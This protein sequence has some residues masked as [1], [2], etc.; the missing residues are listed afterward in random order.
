MSITVSLFGQIEDP[1]EWEF[2]KSH[3]GGNKWELVFTAYIET[4]WSVYSQHLDE[5]GPVPTSINFNSTFGFELLGESGESGSQETGYDKIFEMDV[6]KYHDKMVLTQEIQI[7]PDTREITG[8]VEYMTCDDTRCLPPTPVDFIFHF[9]SSSNSGSEDGNGL[10]AEPKKKDNGTDFGSIDLSEFNSPSPQDNP[11][12]GHIKNPIIWQ[13]RVDNYDQESYTA[14][15]VFSGTIE[16]GWHAYSSKMGSEDGPIPLDILFGEN[17]EGYTFSPLEEDSEE[18]VSG[19]DDIFETDV[20]KLKKSFTLSQDI[21]F[22]DASLPLQGS[23]E[24]MTCT[25]V[26][27]VFPAPLEFQFDPATGVIV[28]IDDEG[29]QTLADESEIAA[30]LLAYY[31]LNPES[32]EPQQAIN[33]IAAEDNHT[34][35]QGS[36]NGRIFFLGFLGGL[37]ALLTPCV[38]P[39][40]PLTVSF[41]TK[42]GDTKG[43]GLGKAALYGGSILAIY[44]IFS[45]PFHFLDT[46]N[47]DILNNISTNVGLNVFF[48]LIFLFFAFSFFGYYE[49]TLPSSWTNKVSNAEGVGGFVGIFFMALTLAL[50]SFSCTGPI[51]GSL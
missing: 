15:L 8:Y 28:L 6:V 21:T 47:P 24:Y 18:T 44:L 2:S 19:Y 45:I 46:I 29:I 49:L 12:S 4:G 9:E 40:I 16:D 41:F 10:L 36:G 26:E 11:G 20:I 1:V 33:C 7:S 27:C 43:G 3:L 38:F 22:A 30:G 25:E 34:L 51:L 17:A 14:T 42:S 39:M 35:I 23:I 31:D 32:L 37:L 13:A 50:V 5:G 48:F